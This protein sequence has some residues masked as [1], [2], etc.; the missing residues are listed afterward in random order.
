M[1]V[2][3]GEEEQSGKEGELHRCPSGLERGG[4]GEVGVGA[5]RIRHGE[6]VRRSL[7]A[8]LSFRCVCDS[9]ET[10]PCLLGQRQRRRRGEERERGRRFR[11]ERVSAEGRQ[12][13]VE[14]M[15]A[16]AESAPLILLVAVAV[17]LVEAGAL[18]CRVDLPLAQ[19]TRERAGLSSSPVRVPRTC[20]RDPSGSE[21]EQRLAKSSPLAAP[22]PTQPNPV[23][24]EQGAGAEPVATPAPTDPLV[25]NSHGSTLP[26]VETTTD[27]IRLARSPRSP[28]VP[29]RVAPRLSHTLTRRI[30]PPTNSI[31]APRRAVASTTGWANSHSSPT[32]AG[33]TNRSLESRLGV[34][35]RSRAR[36][37]TQLSR[38]V[39]LY[40]ALPTV[41]ADSLLARC[42]AENWVSFGLGMRSQASPACSDSLQCSHRV[43][44]QPGDTPRT[45][46]LTN[47]LPSPLLSPSRSASKHSLSTALPRKRTRR[48]NSLR[49]HETEQL[50]SY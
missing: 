11:G 7:T 15:Y 9:T 12:S 27:P 47:L 32:R 3:R 2:G 4:G 48:P 22:V 21:R 38:P 1:K 10:V 5:R 39:L 30:P 17:V 33:R 36:C 37:V 25:S 29:L 31:D 35:P 6:G 16:A 28:W 40:P 23:R 41:H 18:L 42:G 46:A 50:R 14:R 13:R 45:N 8:L 44:Y 34:G 19:S 26:S 43:L 20:D 49:T 24:A